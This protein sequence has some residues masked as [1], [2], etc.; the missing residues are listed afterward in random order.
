MPRLNTSDELWN[1]VSVAGYLRDVS[2]GGTGTLSAEAAAGQKDLVLET[3]EGTNYTAEDYVRV[4]S[5]ELL[6]VA[7]VDSIA[8]DTLSCKSNLAFTHAI[9][10]AVVE[11]EKI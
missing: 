8:T 5:G 6:E 4:G 11:Q 3:G 9:V 1:Y 10:A 2:A 7:Q